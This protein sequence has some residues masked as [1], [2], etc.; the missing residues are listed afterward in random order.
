MGASGRQAFTNDMRRVA[1]DTI[2]STMKRALNVLQGVSV[3]T[4]YALKYGYACLGEHSEICRDQRTARALER[5]LRFHLQ[6]AGTSHAP[7]LREVPIAA[8][9]LELTN[10]ARLTD[11]HPNTLRNPLSE[12][13]QGRMREVVKVISA[14]TEC[15]RAVDKAIHW[16]RNELI[17]DYDRRTAA[18]LVADGQVE[19][20]PA[21]IRNLE[22]GA[23]DES[24]PRREG[25]DCPLQRLCA[26]Q[27]SSHRLNK[28]SQYKNDIRV[29]SP[30]PTD[31]YRDS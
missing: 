1:A 14:A 29:A 15:I 9:G 3:V 11:V 13:L 27:C 5:A 16:Y 24:R 17:A 20:V 2:I 31:H 25:W 6:L 22:N 7:Y 18:E 8:P 28:S 12:R 10:L 23:R 26:L 21:F 19:A 30:D 4:C